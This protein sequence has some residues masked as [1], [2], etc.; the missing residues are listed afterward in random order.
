MEKR[1]RNDAE[2][3]IGRFIEYEIFKGLILS[4]IGW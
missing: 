2:N 1:S 4:L 3:W